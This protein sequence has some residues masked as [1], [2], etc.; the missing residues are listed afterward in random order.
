[1]TI[2]ASAYDS[3]QGL[4]TGAYL[5]ARRQLCC[6]H[7]VNTAAYSRKTAWTRLLRSFLWVAPGQDQP[8]SRDKKAQTMCKQHEQDP[9]HVFESRSPFRTHIVH[10]LVNPQG[11]SKKAFTNFGGVGRSAAGC[12]T[13]DHLHQ[14]EQWSRDSISKRRA[15]VVVCWEYRSTTQG[16]STVSYR[17]WHTPSHLRWL[18]SVIKVATGPDLRSSQRFLA[19]PCRKVSTPQ[20]RRSV[21]DYSFRHPR[22]RQKNSSDIKDTKRLNEQ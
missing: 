18:A 13:G 5:S 7:D 20:R 19:G 21:G 15:S 1:M 4:H 8:A 11:E 17:Q 2:H 6:C 3:L 14:H 16:Y 12:R 9:K 22:H 10:C